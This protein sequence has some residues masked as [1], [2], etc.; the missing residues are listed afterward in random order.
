MIIMILITILILI[1]LLLIIM[2]ITLITTILIITISGFQGIQEEKEPRPREPACLPAS[3]SAH[4]RVSHPRQ[5][6]MPAWLALPAIL[7]GGEDTVDWDAVGSNCSI[8]NCLFTSN[9]RNNSNNSKWE[10][11]ARW[12]FPTVSSSFLTY[13]PA[14]QLAS[15]PAREPVEGGGRAVM[16]PVSP[17]LVHERRDA[18]DLRRTLF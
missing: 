15:R 16:R 7:R 9:K 14:S 3:R 2:M 6:C 11:W 18:E 12:G 8:E 1:L 4:P 10:I 13:A 17:D 5:P